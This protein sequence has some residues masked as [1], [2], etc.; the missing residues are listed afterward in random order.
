MLDPLIPAVERLDPKR[1]DRKAFRCGEPELDEY[2]RR[3]ASQNEKAGAGR[4]YVAVVSPGDAEV[5]G[6]YA[7][8][9]GS[10]KYAEVPDDLRRRLGRYPVPVVQLTR[11]AVDQRHQGRRLGEFLLL[12]ALARILA[13]STEIGVHAVDVIALNDSAR[14]FYLKYGFAPLLDDER[15]LFLPMTTV[16]QVLPG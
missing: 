7:L 15:H 13:L 2:L 3:F 5:L 14:G 6:Y 10:V 8:A 11:L 9:A 4:H 16:V 1:H 12:D